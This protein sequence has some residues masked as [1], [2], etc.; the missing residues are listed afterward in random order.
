MSQKY[1]KVLT[2]VIDDCCKTDDVWACTHN[3]QQLEFT[4]ILEMFDIHILEGDTDE[5]VEAT[6]TEEAGDIEDPVVMDNPEK[7]IIQ[8]M[9]NLAKVGGNWSEKKEAILTDVIENS[10]LSD[11][12][13]LELAQVMACD[14]LMQIDFSS[15]QNDEAN[16][17]KLLEKGVVILRAEEKVALAEKLYFKKIAKLLGFTPEDIEEAMK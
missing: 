3:Y 9:I 8:F 7:L 1:V 10:T 4:I 17:A 16:S 5:Y 11:D 12:E 15:L 13:Q 2:T 14:K 6:F